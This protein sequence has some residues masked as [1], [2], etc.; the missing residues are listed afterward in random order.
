M[1]TK[2]DNGILSFNEMHNEKAFCVMG[3]IFGDGDRFVRLMTEEEI[4]QD[5]S[6]QNDGWSKKLKE[7]EVGDSSTYGYW[8]YQ[9]ANFVTRLA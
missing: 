8:Y 5:G 7:L 3:T 4:N 1:R 6:M 9:K 2:F